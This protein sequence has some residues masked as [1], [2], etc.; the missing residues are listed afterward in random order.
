MKTAAEWGKERGSTQ[1]DLDWEFGKII[2]L[3]GRPL[4]GMAVVLVQDGETVYEGHFGARRFL[5]SCEG[6][7]E[8]EGAL[9][10]EGALEPKGAFEPVDRET[11]WRSA[12]LSKP[13][14]TLGVL[15]LVEEGKIGLDKDV[16]YYLGY[17]LRNPS[18]PEKA[19][20]L[21][22]LLSHTSSLRDANFY[23]PPL[24]HQLWELFLPQG[25][26]YQDGA[27]FAKPRSDRDLSPGAA[28]SYC[29]LGYALVGEIIEKVTGRRFDLYMRDTLFGPL[30]IDGGFNPLLVSDRHFADICPLYRKQKDEDSP[31]DPQGPWYPQIDNYNGKRP[32]LAVRLPPQDELDAGPG[33][34]RQVGSAPSLDNYQIGTNGALFSPQGGMYVC[35]HDLARL[36]LLFLNDG[37]SGRR[38]FEASTIDSMLTPVWSLDLERKNYDPMEE[39]EPRTRDFG[40]GLY[41]GEGPDGGPGLWGHHGDAYGFLGGMY[42]DRSRRSGYVYQIGGT[43]ADPAQNRGERSRLFIWD[44]KVRSLAEAVLGLR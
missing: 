29:N 9:K 38:L 30:G 14:T 13:F 39:S 12:S 22:M 24:G 37:V 27:H 6:A 33:K 44:E 28:Y 4:S 16:S 43:G 10:H 11:R 21:R 18:F 31:W 1:K 15:H 2:A 8:H 41:R 32:A 7:L 42:F 36:M 40:L 26:H 23:Y 5:T 35:A 25:R 17:P 20:T 34:S 19:I 3:P